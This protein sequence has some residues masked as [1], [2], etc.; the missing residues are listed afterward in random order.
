MVFGAIG[1]KAKIS[2]LRG[3]AAYVKPEFF[4]WADQESQHLLIME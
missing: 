3:Y 4:I 1:V 2:V